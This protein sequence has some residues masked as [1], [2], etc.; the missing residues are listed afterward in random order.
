MS[1][2]V[3]VIID[4]LHVMLFYNYYI[5]SL[6]SRRCTRTKEYHVEQDLRRRSQLFDACIVIENQFDELPQTF[7]YSE[8]SKCTQL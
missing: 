3:Q 7:D 4:L 1:F 8:R 6:F 5:Y 2:L